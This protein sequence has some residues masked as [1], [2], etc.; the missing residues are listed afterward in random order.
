MSPTKP[1]AIGQCREF[2][3]RTRGNDNMT[4]HW[5][6]EIRGGMIQ[7]LSESLEAYYEM[8]GRILGAAASVGEHAQAGA[9]YVAAAGAVGCALLFSF[10]Y[11]TQAS[12][13]SLG[14]LILVMPLL[15]VVVG[16]IASTIALALV[17]FLFVQLPLYVLAG[18]LAVGPWIFLIY[19]LFS[20][21][22]RTN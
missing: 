10:L 20:T 13:V 9:Q 12:E 8:V 22:V 4:S 11:F 21:I 2:A 3:T 7:F 1:A 15:G 6:M 17:A 16:A 18:I 14:V 5:I 19:V